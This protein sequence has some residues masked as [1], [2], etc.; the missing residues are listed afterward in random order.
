V[1]T[2]AIVYVPAHV[3]LLVCGKNGALGTPFQNHSSK[4]SSAIA[5]ICCVM[6]FEYES[7]GPAISALKSI[8]LY[9]SVRKL[10]PGWQFHLLLELEA[11]VT[12]MVN[13]AGF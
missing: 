10:P 2:Y 4:T 11:L 1:P 8:L 6:F 3:L 12:P 7:H 9:V 5:L 13:E